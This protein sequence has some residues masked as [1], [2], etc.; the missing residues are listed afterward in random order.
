MSNPYETSDTAY[1]RTTPGWYHAFYHVH[2]PAKWLG[3]GLFIMSWNGIVPTTIGWVGFAIAVAAIVGSHFLPKLAGV[4]EPEW[5]VLTTRMLE[6]RNY[7]YHAA[8]NRFR[9]GG[10]L[11]YEGNSFAFRPDNQIACGTVASVPASELNETIAREDAR[12]AR[13]DFD[14]LVAESPEFA[15]FVS[16]YTF[17]VSLFSEFGNSAIELCQIVDDRFK[18]INRPS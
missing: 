4:S 9:S 1:V 12:Q 6:T 2:E 18:W 7:S 16:G 15:E 13:I 14:K 3:V 11:L 10:V 17:R 8:M 5:A